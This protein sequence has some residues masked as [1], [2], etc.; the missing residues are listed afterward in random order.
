MAKCF[1]ISGKDFVTI[2][3]TNCPS[4]AFLHGGAVKPQCKSARRQ[5]QCAAL[6]TWGEEASTAREPPQQV[7]GGKANALHLPSHGLRRPYEARK[8][9]PKDLCT[10]YTLNHRP[11]GWKQSTLGLTINILP[12]YR[13]REGEQR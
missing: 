7:T 12:T 1:N 6:R 10:N 13:A 8:F 9:P 2:T 11:Y 5:R 3:G 4:A